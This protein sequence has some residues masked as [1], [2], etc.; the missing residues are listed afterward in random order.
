MAKIRRDAALT[1]VLLIAG[2]A[3]ASTCTASLLDREY[4]AG[5]S[6]HP[7]IVVTMM[8]ALDAS[9]LADFNRL[10]DV[11]VARPEPRPALALRDRPADRAPKSIVDRAARAYHLRL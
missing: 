5:T 8:P 3:F 2:S 9:V 11:D 1:A 6:N 7:Y 4:I 10:F